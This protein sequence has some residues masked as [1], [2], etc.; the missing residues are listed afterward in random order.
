MMN[1]Y[2]FKLI[3]EKKK[4]KKTEE[5]EKKLFKKDIKVALKMMMP[6][7]YLII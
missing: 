2:I 7:F 1:C 5:D 6:P 3:H 4:I